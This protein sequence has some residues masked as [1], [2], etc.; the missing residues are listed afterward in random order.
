MSFKI[1]FSVK[2]EDIRKLELISQTDGY[3]Q[4]LRMNPE[5][6]SLLENRA[7]LMEA[8]S[9]I[10]VEGTVLSYDQAKA[11]TVGEANVEV[12]EKER[13]EFVGYYESLEFIKSKLEEPL[14]ISLLLH[15]HEKI[16][17]GDAAAN[18]GK[19]RADIRAVSSRGKVIY[20]APLRLR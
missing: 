5:W 17:T 2:E 8:V 13:R 11:I 15:I 19:V 18:P 12:G 16:T 1:N 9:S 3:L 4:V 14:N 20:K 6:A 10:G 7:R